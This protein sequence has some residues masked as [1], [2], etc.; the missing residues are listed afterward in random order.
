LAGGLKKL[1]TKNMLHLHT[2]E[3]PGQEDV[4]DIR[5]AMESSEKVDV[6]VGI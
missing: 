4:A 6:V 3:M 5:K 2:A 1:T